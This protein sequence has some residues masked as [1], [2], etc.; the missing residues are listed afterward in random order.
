MTALEIACDLLNHCLQLG[1]RAESLTADT[2]L[3]GNFPEFNSMTVVALITSIEDRLGCE[4]PDD[5][6][7][8][9]IF[10]TVGTLAAFIESKR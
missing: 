6:I 8:G 10:E 3:M 1:S 4:V 7:S 5:E 9:E 2:P